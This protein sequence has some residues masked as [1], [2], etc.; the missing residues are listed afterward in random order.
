MHGQEVW[1]LP[2]VEQKPRTV[3]LIQLKN[4]TVFLW[5]LKDHCVLFAMLV[6]CQFCQVGFLIL[7]S[8]VREFS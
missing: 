4:R 6:N 5:N 8:F 7:D 1:D 2:H 3:D